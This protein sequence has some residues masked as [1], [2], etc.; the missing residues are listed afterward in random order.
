[1]EDRIPGWLQH[2][3]NTC[4]E[5]DD[6]CGRWACIFW[7][8]ISLWRYSFQTGGLIYDSYQ[9]YILVS[10]PRIA[11]WN[12]TVKQVTLISSNFLGC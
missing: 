1:M 4:C 5:K 7:E 8:M 12:V 2:C 3:H 10:I 11:I 6:H 9:I